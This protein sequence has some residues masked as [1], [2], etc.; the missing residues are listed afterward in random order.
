MSELVQMDISGRD[1]PGITV[2]L[3][4]VLARHDVTVLDIGQSVI[5]NT[6][7]LGMLLDV[8]DET[9]S[10]V[11]KE[12]LFAAHGLGLELRFTPIDESDY[13]TWVL[14]QGQP[15]HILTLL[16]RSI[17]A[18]H[19]A[20]VS[21][22]V[23]SYGL[24]IE[25][26]TRLSGRISRLEGGHPQH[27]SIEI[28]LKGQV[29]DISVLHAELLALGSELNLDLAVQEDDIFRRNRRLV[30]FDMDSTLIQA[31]VIDVLAEAAGVGA[32]VAAITE[33]AMR[34]ELDFTES[35]QQRL[36]LLAGLDASILPSLAENLPITPGAEKLIHTLKKV[37]YRVVILSG[38]FDYFAHFLQQRLDI[39]EVHANTLDI[40]DGKL[41]GQ[42]N[43]PVVDGPRKAKLLR[44]IAERE[45][46]RLE[47]VI[48]VGDGANDLPMLSI[49][50]LGIA[51]R[52]KPL[53]KQR[54]RHALGTVG[55][56]GILYLLGMRDRDITS[57]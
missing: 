9:S 3:T 56:D 16:G 26:V 7:A 21:S 55:L 46:I 53:V 36:S 48:A 22:V 52:A 4:E 37:G 33:S 39:D 44:E 57:L 34:G 8:P 40:R 10:P 43:G 1:R 24:N 31:E 51:Y 25:Q 13:E 54:A 27:A 41:T 2:A 38:G 5:H 45:G 30:C 32:Q 11:F 29:T 47:Q 49:A 28:W 35:F 14:E 12:L 18:G 19:I 23:A 50:G 20:R 17:N 42:I 6:L 15:R